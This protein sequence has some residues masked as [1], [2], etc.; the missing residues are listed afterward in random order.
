MNYSVGKGKGNSDSEAEANALGE[1]YY[2]ELFGAN[3]K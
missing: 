3:K 1:K 2:D